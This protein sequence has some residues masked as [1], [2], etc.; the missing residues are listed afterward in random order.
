MSVSA[1]AQDRLRDRLAAIAP[2]QRSACMTLAFDYARWHPL[3]RH[4][5]RVAVLDEPVGSPW[6]NDSNGNAVWAIVENGNVVTFMFRRSTQR[7]DR[8][9]F[10]VD[11]LALVV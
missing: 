1:H 8:A 4:A 11:K 9:S 2:D 10:N 6:D 3:G 5:V 7:V